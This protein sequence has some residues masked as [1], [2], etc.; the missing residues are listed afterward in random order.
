VRHTA[1]AISAVLGVLFVPFIIAP[2][3]SEHVGNAITSAS[4]MA[5]ITAQEQGAPGDPWAGIAVTIAWAAGA[6]LIA[7][8]LVA[9][10]D[11]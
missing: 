2:L 1:F 4:P 3:F 5:G 8:W 9:R 6:L 10:R 11:A 7:L